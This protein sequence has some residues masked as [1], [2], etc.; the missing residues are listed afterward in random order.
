M[1]FIGDGFLPAQ[2]KTSTKLIDLLWRLIVVSNCLTIAKE[3][4]IKFSFLVLCFCWIVGVVFGMLPPAPN[5]K[6]RFCL[7]RP[8]VLGSEVLCW[9]PFEELI[10]DGKK[11]SD[12]CI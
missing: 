11:L 6:I 2:A 8:V 4:Q 3:N 7:L 5:E 10:F 1:C 9:V 12:V